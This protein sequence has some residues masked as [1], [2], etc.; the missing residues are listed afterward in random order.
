MYV[1]W[2][3]NFYSIKLTSALI[4]ENIF[5]IFEFKDF[6]YVQF[7]QCPWLVNLSWKVECLQSLGK[8]TLSP[9]KSNVEDSRRCRHF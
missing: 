1:C 9:G 4:K 7:V 2:H 3:L 8:H 6:E 5:K